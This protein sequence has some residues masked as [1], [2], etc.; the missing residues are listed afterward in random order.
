MNTPSINLIPNTHFAEIMLS[1]LAKHKPFR[2]QANG[3]SMCPF[4]T[5]GDILTISPMNIKRACLGD[6]VAVYRPGYHLFIHRVISLRGDYIQ[7]KG[8]NSLESDGWYLVKEIIGY[9][10]KVERKSKIV[11]QGLGYERKII[12]FFS[13]I[14]VL[15]TLINISRSIRKTIYLRKI[16]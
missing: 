12:A 15:I 5:N 9:V 14:G 4:I 1:V 11:T 16:I 2:F 7:T 3:N 10:S 13:K 6:V 8:D